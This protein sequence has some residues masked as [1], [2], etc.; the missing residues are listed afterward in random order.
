MRVGIIGHEGLS[1]LTEMLVRGELWQLVTTFGSYELVG[2]TCLAEGPETWFAQSVLD[3]GGKVEVIVSA[4]AGRAGAFAGKGSKARQR[5]LN[6]ANAVHRLA[7]VEVG[8]L[9]DDTCRAL[10]GMIDELIAVWDGRPGSEAA[11]VVEAAQ[12]AGLYV[13]VVWPDGCESPAE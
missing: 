6:E 10:V 4:S 9:G 12:R 8:G 1:D 7:P 13:Q 3:H 11:K 2:V 5:L